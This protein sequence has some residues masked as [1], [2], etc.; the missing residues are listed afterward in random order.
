MEVERGGKIEYYV[1]Y[2][3]LRQQLRSSLLFRFNVD[4]SSLPAP[5][6]I[7]PCKDGGEYSEGIVSVLV[8]CAWRFVGVR[9]V[10]D[11]A[12]GVEENNK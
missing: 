12:D 11:D 10:A 1:L 9:K 3:V 4:R 8:P 5:A 6:A 7:I 2:R